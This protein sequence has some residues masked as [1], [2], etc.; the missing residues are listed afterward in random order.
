M[1]GATS[2]GIVSA[3]PAA[4]WL[5]AFACATGAAQA[6][7][8]CPERLRIAFPDM[9]A[10][11]FVRGQGS[12]F[13]RPPGLLVAWVRAALRELG[14]LERAELMR[15]PPRR[16]RAMIEAGQLELAAGVA[17]G[18]PVASLLTLPPAAG[19]RQEHDLSLGN[20]DY[21]LYARRDRLPDAD[22][23]GVPPQALVGVTAGSRAD[24][25]A[26]GRGWRTEPAPNHE[27]AL[28]KLLAGRTTHLLVHSY[29]LEERL[30]REPALARHVMRVGPAVER[31]RLHVG[32]L[33]AF[34][35]REASFMSRLW[36]ALCRQSAAAGAD[37]ACRP[38]P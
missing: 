8:A 4:A 26:Q 15:L 12:D 6:T 28:Q 38:P 10:E 34:A 25:L 37:G 13:E 31:L 16:V 35:E 20:V 22:A 14:C 27:S 3:R 17:A 33:P 29:F 21:V 7:P 2:R 19:P 18:G 24:A 30:R 5:L 9:A 23:P 1:D 11:P 32:A 36:L